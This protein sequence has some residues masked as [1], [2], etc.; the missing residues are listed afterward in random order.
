MKPRALI[1]LRVRIDPSANAAKEMEDLIN[2]QFSNCLKKVSQLGALMQ[3]FYADIGESARNL[4]RPGL[5]A[6]LRRLASPFRDVDLVVVESLDRL[7]RSP[8]DYAAIDR[9]ITESGAT[10]RVVNSDVEESQDRR[11]A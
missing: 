11:S 8:L 9:A 1:Y 4:E 7:A 2:K 3:D 5:T 6:L 10:L